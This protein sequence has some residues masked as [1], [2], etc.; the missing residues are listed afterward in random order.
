MKK[1]FFLVVLFAISSIS[2]GQLIKS[3]F[4]VDLG[5]SLISLRGN[6]VLDN[7]HNEAIGFSSSIFYDGSFNNYFAIKTGLTFER[8]GSKVTAPG[9]DNLGNDIG[10]VTT[11]FMFDYITIP[12]LLKATVGNNFKCFLNA[13]PYFGFLLSSKAKTDNPN[14]VGSTSGFIK[15]DNG[16]AVGFGV[17]LPRKGQNNLSIELRRNIGNTNISKLPIFN[18]GSIKTNSTCLLLGI[19]IN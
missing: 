17:I 11:N 6:S 4:G 13:G 7:Y 9:T 8:K 19:L 18:F 12:I 15:R 10:L 14:M 5:P 2:F 16:F 3:R 1:V